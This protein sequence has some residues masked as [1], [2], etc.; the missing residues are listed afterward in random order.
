MN[1][2]TRRPPITIELDAEQQQC[3]LDALTHKMA[4]ILDEAA[5]E[6]SAERIDDLQ[7]RLETIVDILRLMDTG[8]GAIVIRGANGEMTRVR[9]LPLEQMTGD[10]VKFQEI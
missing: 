5:G 7:R 3:I 6:P 1:R 9:D 4:G 2:A 10:Y 8:P